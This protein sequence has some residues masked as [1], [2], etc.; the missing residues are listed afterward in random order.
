VEVIVN[1]FDEEEDDW[2]DYD[3][4]TDCPTCRGEGRVPTM[5]FESYFGAMYKPCPTCL[6]DVCA[7]Q[8]RL[9]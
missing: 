4:E 5:D 3:P 9:S 8:P 2:L 7:D 6:G 1:D